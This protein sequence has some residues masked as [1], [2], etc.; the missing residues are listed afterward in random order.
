LESIT[1]LDFNTG[2]SLY[3]LLRINTSVAAHARLLLAKMG[4]THPAAKF[5]DRMLRDENRGNLG[6]D[7]FNMAI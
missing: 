5:A 2:A 6:K 7:D 3:P 4:S 1:Q